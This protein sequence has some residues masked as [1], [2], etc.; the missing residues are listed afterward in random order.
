L[1]RTH[2]YDERDPSEM[3]IELKVHMEGDGRDQMTYR[4][5]TVPIAM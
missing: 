3:D 4:N 5:R 2:E 1:S